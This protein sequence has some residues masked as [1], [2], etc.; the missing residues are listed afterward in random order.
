MKKLLLILISLSF[1]GCSSIKVGDAL[2][3]LELGD[4]LSTEDEAKR[5]LALG[6]SHEENLKE[7]SK[8]ESAHKISIVSLKLTNARDKKIQYS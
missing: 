5:I 2:S 1:I 8:L 7:A 6:L 3:S 4:A